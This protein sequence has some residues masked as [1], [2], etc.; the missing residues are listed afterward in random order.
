[1]QARVTRIRIKQLLG[2]S[3]LAM[4]ICFLSL[5]L[6]LMKS[7]PKPL[8]K[9]Q[10]WRMNQLTLEVLHRHWK[11]YEIERDG[12]LVPFRNWREKE[13][14]ELEFKSPTSGQLL[15]WHVHGN[16]FL[17][18][19]ERHPTR[20]WLWCDITAEHFTFEYRT[21]ERV[22]R[23]EV[24]ETSRSTNTGSKPASS[25]KGPRSR[26]GLQVTGL[27]VTDTL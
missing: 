27:Q 17:V 11:Q 1:M 19:P 6:A 2:L 16:E 20:G 21:T 9:E 10:C 26:V 3:L 15:A 5:W 12:E 7:K 23:S 4:T 22:A 8:N 18:S 24:T 25:S 14:P 13:R